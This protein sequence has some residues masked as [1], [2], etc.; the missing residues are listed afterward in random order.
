M[1]SLHDIREWGKANGF[2]VNDSGPLPRGLRDAY[3]TR[4]D[5]EIITRIVPDEKEGSRIVDDP[6][7]G[8]AEAKVV[9]RPPMVHKP[10]LVARA[11]RAVGKDPEDA[12]KPAK[13]NKPR[14]SLDRIIERAWDM[15][16]RVIAPVNLPVARVMAVQAPVAG[17]LLEDI[18]K[19]TIVD[20]ILQPIA[21]VEEKGELAFALIGPPLLVGLLT[22]ERGQQLAPVLVP[23]LKES[24]R[25]WLEVAGPKI[26][27]AR[28][29]EEEFAAKYGAQIDV[30]I[31]TFFAPPDGMNAPDN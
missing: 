12:P 23:A 29:R 22:S 2:D 3:R 9:E 1:A 8:E 17:L 25:V 28:K 19:G 30:L 7:D 13:A 4:D 31:E 21:S 24:L 15:L 14:R 5:S 6:D 10:S 20:K 16:G 11:R 27:I 26:E 18:V